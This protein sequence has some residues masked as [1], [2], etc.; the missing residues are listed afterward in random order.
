[1]LGVVLAGGQSSRFGSDKAMAQIAGRSLIAIAVDR[2]SGWCD[3]VVIAGREF[4]PARCIPDEPGPGMGPLGG[5]LAALRLAADEG[6]EL[7]L[8]CS[9]D[10]LDLPEDL[11]EQLQPAPACLAQQPVVGL[12][13]ASAGAAL[14]AILQGDGKRSMWQFAEAI[15]ARMIETEWQ[16]ANINTPADLARYET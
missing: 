9:V 3:E 7:V 8:S 1:M 13:P 6:H 14:D 15:G 5:L 11:P 2:L 4:G 16:A 10:C 12:W